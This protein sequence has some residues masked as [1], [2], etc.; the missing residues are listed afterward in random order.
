MSCLL[1]RGLPEVNLFEASL[2]CKQPPLEEAN[3]WAQEPF[4]IGAGEV[5]C[6]VLS[7]RLREPAKGVANKASHPLNG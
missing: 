3:E 7:C 5:P 2:A 4:A 1:Q 6:P